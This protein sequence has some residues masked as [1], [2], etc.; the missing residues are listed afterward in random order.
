MQRIN[1][2][3]AAL[4]TAILASSVPSGVMAEQ[5][6][7]PNDPGYSPPLSAKPLWNTLCDQKTLTKCADGTC[8][9]TGNGDAGSVV[10]ISLPNGTTASIT[11]DINGVVTSK[12]NSDGVDSPT[13]QNQSPPGSGQTAPLCRNHGI[14][15]GFYNYYLSACPARG[16]PGGGLASPAVRGWKVGCTAGAD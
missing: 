16:V 6:G 10:K 15:C 3:G 4:L 7:T 14:G 11:L 2:T 12:F 13:C 5:P 8:T 9:L 1:K